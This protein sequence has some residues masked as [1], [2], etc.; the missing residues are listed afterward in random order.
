MGNNFSY[1]IAQ[2]LRDTIRKLEQSSATLQNDPAMVE[3]KRQII[4]TIA[5]LEIVKEA[6]AMPVVVSVPTSHEPR[7]AGVAS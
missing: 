1:K 7:P 2:L 3:V 4:R 6:A 5:E